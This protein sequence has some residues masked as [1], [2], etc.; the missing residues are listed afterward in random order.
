M[1]RRDFLALTAAITVAMPLKSRAAPVPYTPGLVAERLRAGDTVLVDFH[2]TWCGT[3]A[4][5]TRVMDALKAENPAY[6]QAVTFIQVD[7]DTYK[8]DALTTG[9]NIPRRST[10]VV[11][12]GESEIGRIVAGT[13]RDEIKGLFDA[14]L[15]AATAS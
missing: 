14:A 13:S 1:Q 6:E 4:A 7:W 2:A 9:L 15:G 3:C 11:L 5:Q 10:L 12:K 8:N